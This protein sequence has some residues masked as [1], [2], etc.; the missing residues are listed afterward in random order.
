MCNNII[1]IGFMGSGKTTIGRMLANKL[2]NFLIDTDDIIELNYDIKISD[3]FQKFGEIK[4]RE[5][6]ISLCKWIKT[7]IKNS[8]ISTGGG[9]P[10][11]YNMRD[12]GNVI[13]L[14]ITF[15]EIQ[16]RIINDGI[17]NRPMIKDF[18]QLHSLY[19]ERIQIY[20]NMAHYIV[21]A[22]DSKNNIVD[23]IY[24]YLKG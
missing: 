23:K 6:E 22:S 11:I 21:N 19:N 5:L 18:K 8:V 4:F 3:F 24:N 2:N 20:K 13:Y 7:N 10:I 16:K 17:Q 1:L 12:M 15:E 14:D 9:M